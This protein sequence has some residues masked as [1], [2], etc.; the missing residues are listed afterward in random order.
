MPFIL[1]MHDILPGCACDCSFVNPTDSHMY[2]NK[3]EGMTLASLLTGCGVAAVTARVTYS[4][5]EQ[6]CL[7][8]MKQQ[9]CFEERLKIV[10][11]TERE[12]SAIINHQ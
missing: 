6:T 10:G 3:S 8:N 7:H 1:W 5:Y 12:S 9:A 4:N 11:G 2:I